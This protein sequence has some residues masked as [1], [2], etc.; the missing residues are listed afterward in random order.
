M[1]TGPS[2][3]GSFFDE[4]RRRKVIRT[5]LLYVVFCWGTLQV[6][7]ILV[8]PLGYDGKQ[9]SHYLLYFA[10][11]GFPV[12]LALAWFLKLTPRGFEVKRSFVDRRILKNIPPIHERRHS[13][14][15]T[16]FHKGEEHRHFNWI[17]SA[18]TG[19][20]TGLSFGVEEP[21]I[22]GR[23]LDCD[24]AIV[25][26]HVSCQHAR[27]DFDDDRLFIEDLGSA[28]GTMVNG[29]PALGRQALHDQDELRF[30]EIVFRVTESFPRS[31][32][33]LQSISKTTS[34]DVSKNFDKHDKDR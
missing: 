14:V 23:S 22:F 7:D 4:L 6:V 29:K 15:S 34:I 21:L 26:P 5:C 3:A 1:T 10:T 18:E 16:Y 25:S 2:F 20:L 33:E 11:A 17:V 27:L 13:R 19:P 28:N 8:P 32:R 9:I 12:I 31:D 30:H 24:I